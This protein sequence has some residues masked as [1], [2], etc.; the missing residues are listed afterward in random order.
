MAISFIVATLFTS[1]AISEE[2]PVKKI[3][4][5]GDSTVQNYPEDENKRGWGQILPSFFGP[6]VECR[7]AAAG[8]RSTKTFISEGRWKKVLEGKPDVIFIQFG[9]NDSHAKDKPESTDASTDY[10]EY[11]EKYVSEGKAA[12]AKVILVTPMH[13]RYFNS[14]GKVKDILGPYAETMRNVAKATNTPLI[15]LHQK[16]RELLEKL[17]DAGSEDLYCSATDRTHFSKKGAIVMAGFIVEAIQKDIPE[18]KP[19]LK[20]PKEWPE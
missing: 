3:I 7:N 19:Y 17:G 18:L 8:G 4:F 11:L 12:G 9:H 16:S 1:T 10:K 2:L 13:R 14:E 5:V 15:D 6:K 20:E